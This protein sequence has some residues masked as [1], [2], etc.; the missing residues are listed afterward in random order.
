MAWRAIRATDEE[1]AS[2]V[3]GKG[4]AALGG[5]DMGTVL[6]QQRHKER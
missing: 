1:G 2:E 6:N 3:A 4:I 5:L